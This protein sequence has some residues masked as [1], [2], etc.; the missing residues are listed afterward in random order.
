[1]AT[2]GGISALAGPLGARLDPEVA[3]AEGSDRRGVHGLDR[4]RAGAC[5]R[6]AWAKS[7]E[8]GWSPSDLDHDAAPV[9]EHEAAEAALGGEPVHERPEADAL[10]DAAD[11]DPPALGRAVVDLHRPS[12]R[13]FQVRG[14]ERCG[15]RA[16][17]LIR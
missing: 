8:R 13:Y 2:S 11:D 1:M 7:L 4:A 16:R 6:S 9:V 12:I 17:S 14:Q 5:S 10:H 3:L 15:G